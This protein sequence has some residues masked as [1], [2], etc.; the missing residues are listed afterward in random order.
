MAKTCFTTYNFIANDC[1]NESAN[2]CKQ[3]SV[4]LCIVV[5][6]IVLI[7]VDNIYFYQVK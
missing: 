6:K 7:Q 1:A 3:T 5:L 4:K 2:D